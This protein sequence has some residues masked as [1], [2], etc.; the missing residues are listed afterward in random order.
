MKLLRTLFVA[1]GVLTLS[2]AT[3]SAQAAQQVTCK[4]GAKSAAG[5]GACSG[6]GGLAVVA[7]TDAKVAKTE[8]KADA[9]VAKTEA[10][11]AAKVEKTT[12]ADAKVAKHPKHKAKKA[13]A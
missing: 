7:K 2:A 11:A 12:T 8:M 3:L 1:S 13:K 5:R 6:H 10:K 4:D 9:K